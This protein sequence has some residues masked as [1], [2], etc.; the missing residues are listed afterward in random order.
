MRKIKIKK[1]L[2]KIESTKRREREMATRNGGTRY[3]KM[4]MIE[5]RR[6]WNFMKRKEKSSKLYK[7]ETGK[8]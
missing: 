3:N 2:A 8:V 5:K 1:T 6:R 4:L 7:P